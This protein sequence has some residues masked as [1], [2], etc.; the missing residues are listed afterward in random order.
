MSTETINFKIGLSGTGSEHQCHFKIF[1]DDKELI[2]ELSS[3]STKLYSFDTELTSGIH[4]LKIQLLDKSSIHTTKDE[5]DNVSESYMLNID[6]ISIDDIDLGQLK[7]DMGKYYPIYPEEY[8]DLEQKK[9]AE[10]DKCVNLGWNGTWELTFE[11]PFY[12][13]LLENI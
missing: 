6:S 13:W 4:K 7:W 3:P 1:I 12:I 10:I 11:S 9:Q 2:N 8:N 5:L